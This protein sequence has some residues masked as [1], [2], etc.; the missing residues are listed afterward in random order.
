MKERLLWI[1]K[2]ESEKN[3]VSL[4]ELML[5]GKDLISLGV[6][7]GKRMGEILQLAFD[8]VLQEPK[9]N[10]KEKLISYLQESGLLDS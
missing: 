10:E 4:S 7:P 8:R 6:S 3:C 1:T 5:S 2:V 9:E